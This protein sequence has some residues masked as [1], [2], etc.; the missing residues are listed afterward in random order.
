MDGAKQFPLGFLVLALAAYANADTIIYEFNGIVPPG[1]SSHSQVMDGEAWTVVVEVD[2]TTPDNNPSPERG[3]YPNSVISSSITFSGGYT[4][5]QTQPDATTLIFDDRPVN[6]P[7]VFFDGVSVRRVAPT[8]ALL[9]QVVVEETM[10]PVSLLANDSLIAP[11]L[12]FAQSSSAVLY[13]QLLFVDE[14][15][16]GESVSYDSLDA[17]NAMFVSFTATADSDSDGVADDVDNC[18]LVANP[19]QIDSNGDGYGNFCDADLNN[20]GIV[21]AIDL[22]LFKAVFFTGDDD[23]DFNGDMIVNVLDLGLLRVGFFQPPG[24][25]ALAP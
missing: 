2:D 15:L 14:L 25:S 16:P 12:S 7:G 3:T 5:T 22:G 20:D 21:N 1:A 13:N 6:P 18:T 10:A 8:S 24:P 19:L 11:G 17:A 9:V 23:A 4:Q